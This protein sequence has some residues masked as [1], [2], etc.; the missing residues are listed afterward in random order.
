MDLKKIYNNY[1]TKYICFARAVRYLNRYKC[2]LSD[3]PIHKTLNL[4]HTRG[5]IG[6]DPPNFI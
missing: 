5:L 6:K 4:N 2:S 3:E 1:A